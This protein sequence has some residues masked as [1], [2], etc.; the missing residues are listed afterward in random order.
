M[1]QPGLVLVVCVLDVLDEPVLGPVDLVAADRHLQVLQ[2]HPE[3]E[4]DEMDELDE[5]GELGGLDELV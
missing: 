3:P 2:H 4:L 1:L 5:L